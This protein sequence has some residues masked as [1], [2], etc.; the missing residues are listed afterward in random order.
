MLPSTTVADTSSGCNP[1]DGLPSAIETVVLVK[2][3]IPNI[4]LIS[5]VMSEYQ[6]NWNVY[7]F[8]L[9]S[10]NEHFILLGYIANVTQNCPT[11]FLGSFI[12]SFN[13]GSS[14]YCDETGVWDVCSDR[15][16]IVVNYTMC[17]AK[18]FYSSRLL[19][20]FTTIVLFKHVKI[21]GY[22]C[23]IA[24]FFRRWCCILRLF[25][26]CREYLLRHS[27]QC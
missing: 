24:L 12:Y 4:Y 6:N 27:G 5:N 25:D 7:L 21:L 19:P 13:D 16:Q 3:G 18:Q 9:V 11:P 15:T 1:S 26:V 23:K 22:T 8:S 10:R 2:K 20:D 17:S 14:T